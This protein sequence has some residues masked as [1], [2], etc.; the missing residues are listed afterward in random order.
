M[1]F[2]YFTL[3]KLITLNQLNVNMKIIAFGNIWEQFMMNSCLLVHF[4]MFSDTFHLIK[5]GCQYVPYL[6]YIT[7]H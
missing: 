7:D 2:T 6:A 4:W 5:N 3:P 1:C